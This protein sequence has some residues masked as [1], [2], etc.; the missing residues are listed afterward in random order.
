MI[1]S[2]VGMTALG[3]AVGGDAASV[4]TLHFPIGCGIALI[5]WFCFWGSE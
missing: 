2:V 5:I 4:F 3:F 1:G